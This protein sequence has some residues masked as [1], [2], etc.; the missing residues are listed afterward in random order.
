MVIIQQGKQNRNKNIARV[1]LRKIIMRLS[2][3]DFFRLLIR[4][5]K[6]YGPIFKLWI[7][8]RPFVFISNADD[9]RPILS[10]SLHIDK[11]YEY[12]FLHPWVGTGLLTSTGK[13]HRECKNA[14]MQQRNGGVGNTKR[15][16][17]AVLCTH[18]RLKESRGRWRLRTS[19]GI[20][21]F[22]GFPSLTSWQIFSL[23]II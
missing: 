4:C 16:I 12:N 9:I 20:F 3:A 8:M 17:L 13:S 7:G 15:K 18:P 2:V 23:P 22:Q 5:G 6:E 11:S 1:H 19:P 10:S 21:V 14:K